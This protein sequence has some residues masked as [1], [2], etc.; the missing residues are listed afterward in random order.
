MVS[1]DSKELWNLVE[2]VVKAAG[3]ELFD[4]EQPRGSGGILRVFIC[5]GSSNSEICSL[6]GVGNNTDITSQDFRDKP[7][8]DKHGIDV[9]DCARINKTLINM[10]EIEAFMPG[11]TVLEVS[12]PG[13]NRKLTCKEHFSGAVGERVK[14][15]SH[16]E[17]GQGRE[18]IRGILKSFD[19]TFL[20][21]DE[22]QLKEEVTV[23]YEKVREARVDFL[24]R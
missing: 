1:G 22:E 8:I 4:I 24:F 19:G 17:E 16:K 3:L 23:S 6:S 20:C 15:V 5:R 11:D 10:P 21:V 9:S 18:V 12:S 13:I 2:P 7:V 14:I